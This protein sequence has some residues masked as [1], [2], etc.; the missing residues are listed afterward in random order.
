MSGGH[1][2]HEDDTPPPAWQEW[3][4]AVGMLLFLAASIVLSG[5]S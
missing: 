3:V 2:A 1:F 4:A 5:A